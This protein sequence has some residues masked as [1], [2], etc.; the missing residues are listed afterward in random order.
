MYI[1]IL[2]PCVY[3]LKV[4]QSLLPPESQFGLAGLK[5]KTTDY[6][7]VALSN[8]LTIC[9]RFNFG[10]LQNSILFDIAN[11][12]NEH[13]TNLQI[14]YP[15]TWL[16]FGDSRNGPKSFASWVMQDPVTEEYTIFFANKWHHLCLSY[17]TDGYIRVTLVSKRM[18]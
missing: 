2:L 3:S 5:L 12:K 1:L 11:K 4:Y 16:R 14:K 15:N 17:E 6:N 7:G 13:Y 10:R 8:S 9:A 18:F